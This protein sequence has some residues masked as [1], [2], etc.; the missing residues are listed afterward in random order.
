[1][2]HAK[3]QLLHRD[4][5]WPNI[6]QSGS[7]SRKWFLIDWDDASTYPTLSATHLDPKTHCPSVFEMGHATEVDIWAVGKLIL[8][9]VVFCS[10]IPADVTQYGMLMMEGQVTSAA[11]ALQYL[12]NHS[13]ANPPD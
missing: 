10:D 8:D 12:S 13:C 9:A 5:R 3:P 4:I 11:A 2:I 7:N 1:M 6:I